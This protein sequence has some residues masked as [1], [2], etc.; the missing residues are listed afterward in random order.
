MYKLVHSPIF[1]SAV[2]KI[3]TQT[4]SKMS[5]E[6][7]SAK[8]LL[9]NERT[10]ENVGNISFADKVLLK[11]RQKVYKSQY[12]NFKFI[13]P[14]SNTVERLFCMAKFVLVDHRKSIESIHLESLLFL[15][16]NRKYCDISTVQKIIS[17]VQ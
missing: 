2:V 7:V 12:L 13:L 3:L 8:T 10:P 14:T 5:E 9:E 11:K 17:K 4:E 6:K 1:E 15:K 16:L